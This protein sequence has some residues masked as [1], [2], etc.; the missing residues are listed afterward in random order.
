MT[1]VPANHMEL[2][3]RFEPSIK[4]ELQTTKYAKWQDTVQAPFNV[5]EYI[6]VDSVRFG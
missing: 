2:E 5:Q 6:Y 4:E 1:G 3:R